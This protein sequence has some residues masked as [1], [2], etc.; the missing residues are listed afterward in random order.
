ML[1]ILNTIFN[2]QLI[3]IHILIHTHT[4]TQYIIHDTQYHIQYILN[5]YLIPYSIYTDTHHILNILFILN[6]ILITLMIPNTILNTIPNTIP[7]TILN[8]YLIYN[9]Y[10]LFPYL[11]LFFPIFPSLFFLFRTLPISPPDRHHS[12]H[13]APQSTW[14]TSAPGC[15]NWIPPA[16]CCDWMKKGCADLS[17]FHLIS[18]EC[19]ILMLC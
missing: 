2:T 7:N 14:Q 16:I 9:L 17:Y 12:T 19:L 6:T 1:F 5:T 18:E 3:L 11:L 13:Q 8:I 15:P 10:T 4:H